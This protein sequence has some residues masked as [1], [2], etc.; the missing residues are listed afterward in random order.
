M[1]KIDVLDT[2]LLLDKLCEKVNIAESFLFCDRVPEPWFVNAEIEI[3]DGFNI[4]IEKGFKDKLTDVLFS[5]FLIT[6]PMHV[7]HLYGR[8][9]LNDLSEKTNNWQPSSLTQIIHPTKL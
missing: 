8:I 3:G 6:E 1:S 4:W 2:C 7:K 9:L 5:I